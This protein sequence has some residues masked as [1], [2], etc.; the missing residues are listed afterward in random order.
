MRRAI[1]LPTQD[2]SQLA[3]NVQVAYFER[4]LIVVRHDGAAH[5]VYGAIGGHYRQLQDVHGF[6][7]LPTSDE[8][9]V[10]NGRRSRFDNGD[11]YWSPATGAQEVHGGIRA[12]WE[13]LGG[14]AGF[15]GYPKTD[16]LPVTHGGAEIGR[17]NEFVGGW[18]YWSG[19]SGAFEVHGDIRRAWIEKYGGPGGALGFPVTDETST[20][21]HL[22]RVLLEKRYTRGSATYGRIASSRLYD[23][24]ADGLLL[25]GDEALQAGKEGIKGL[26]IVTDLGEEWF[27]WQGVPF[28]FARWVVRRKLPREIKMKLENCLRRSLE[29]MSL[30]RDRTARSEA[31]ARS[32]VPRDLLSYWDDFSYSLTPGHHQSISLFEELMAA[33]YA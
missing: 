19:Q 25:I 18:I 16:E 28:V 31:G 9:A 30:H 5:V 6:L 4:G 3:G 13:S 22:L 7:G 23:G 15:L 32:L 10:V 12:K 27:N 2:A 26:P 1:G 14:P 17:T 8:E 11:I 29:S 33:A 20:S 21:V 24:S